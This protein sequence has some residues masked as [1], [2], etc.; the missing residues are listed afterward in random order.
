MNPPKHENLPIL[1]HTNMFHAESN[2]RN[3]PTS[4]IALSDSTEA[5]DILDLSEVPFDLNEQ[6]GLL[7]PNYFTHLLMEEAID[8]TPGLQV[9]TNAPT[10]DV[11][12]VPA[13]S[14]AGG[15]VADTNTTSLSQ[16]DADDN[17][18]SSQQMDPHIRMCYDTLQGANEHYNA[19]AARTGFSIKVNRYRR[20]ARTN[21]LDKQQYVCN[22]FRKPR[23]DDGSGD[24]PDVVGPVL[25]SDSSDEEDRQN[26]ELAS[27]V[28]RIAK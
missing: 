26:P 10:I 12:T 15:F 28:S 20:S 6:V 22:K 5:M 27:I 23:N 2:S 11:H 4:G 24:T 1:N 17:E 8:G 14:E 18:A 21:E 13:D 3:A 16:D 25:D 9:G 19:Y 7:P